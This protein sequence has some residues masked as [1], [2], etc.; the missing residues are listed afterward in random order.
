MNLLRDY[1]RK[2]SV[3]IIPNRI[4]DKTFIE[5][6]DMLNFTK[7]NNKEEEENKKNFSLIQKKNRIFPYKTNSKGSF[8]Q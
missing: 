8:S 5:E 6:V 1:N 4:K 7:I 2:N 3:C